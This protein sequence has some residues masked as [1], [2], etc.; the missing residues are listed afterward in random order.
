M[1]EEH[2]WALA[3]V[4]FAAVVGGG[5]YVGHEGSKRDDVLAGQCIAMGATWVQR[6]GCIQPAA[7]KVK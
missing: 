1:K 6:T 7:A 5:I 2:V 3:L 4:L